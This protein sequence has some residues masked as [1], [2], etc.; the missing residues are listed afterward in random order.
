MKRVYI[1]FVTLELTRYWTGESEL[2]EP[3]ALFQI[4]DILVIFNDSNIIVKICCIASILSVRCSVEGP[5]IAQLPT[6]PDRLVILQ[7][8]SRM[9][10]LFFVGITIG[11]A[12]F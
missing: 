1:F 9:T 10:R 3:A 2:V 4:P 12:F 11:S 8:S 5:K 6:S 7:E